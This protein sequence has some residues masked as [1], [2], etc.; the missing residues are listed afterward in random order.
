MQD[1]AQVFVR[2]QFRQ[3]ASSGAFDLGARFAQFGSDEDRR[4]RLNTSDPSH[5]VAEG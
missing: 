1:A 5:N 3:F 4:T 2:P